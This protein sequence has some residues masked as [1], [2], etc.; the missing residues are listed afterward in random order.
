MTPDEI[1]AITNVLRARG[2][3]DTPCS[4][5]GCNKAELINVYTQ[6]NLSDTP[7]NV[8]YGAQIVPCAIVA[9]IHCGA[10][11]LHNLLRLNVLHPVPPQPQP[12]APAP[13]PPPVPDKTPN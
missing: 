7:L 3:L 4:R 10:I 8:V 2:A 9:C 5:C 6:L 12:S 13:A 1:T 11:T